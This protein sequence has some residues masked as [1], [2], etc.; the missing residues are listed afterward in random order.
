[1]RKRATGDKI[2][3]DIE[4]AKKERITQ[5]SIKLITDLLEYYCSNS[6]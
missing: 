5:S 1:M 4:R 3:N 6:S 2:Y